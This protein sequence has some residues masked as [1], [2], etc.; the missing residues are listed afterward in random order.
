MT[1]M[2][3][4]L[5]IILPFFC[6]IRIMAERERI[7]VSFVLLSI[8][9][10]IL[11]NIFHS[12]FNLKLISQAKKKNP[13]KIA[14]Y[15]VVS[16]VRVLMFLKFLPFILFLW[17][18]LFDYYLFVNI[19]FYFPNLMTLSYKTRL[20]IGTCIFPIYIFGKIN[21][22][23]TLFFTTISFRWS[24]NVR[25]LCFLFENVLFKIIIRDFPR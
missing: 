7:A 12:K 1:F 25:L 16:S 24:R 9:L 14:A 10:I 22:N 20:A 2:L 15:D 19:F 4:G 23:L 13:N 6:Y 8:I 11:I 5:I 18:L 21:I 3:P 17:L